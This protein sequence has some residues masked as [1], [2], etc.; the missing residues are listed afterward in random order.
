MRPGTP[1]S[2]QAAKRDSLWVLDIGSSS[3][4]LPAAG[5]NPSLCPRPLSSLRPATEDTHG[6]G[7]GP[8]L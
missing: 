7:F 4:T 6:R 2:G 5:G 8:Q 3:H 1:D